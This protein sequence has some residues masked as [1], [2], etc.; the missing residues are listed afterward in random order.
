[1]KT[2]RNVEMVSINKTKN[3]HKSNAALA[4]A[5]FGLV[6]KK[7]PFNKSLWASSGDQL[8]LLYEGGKKNGNFFTYSESLKCVD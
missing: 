7:G 5:F 3:R 1:M 6:H 8:R 4:S 2:G